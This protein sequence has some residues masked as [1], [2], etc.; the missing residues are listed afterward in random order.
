MKDQ[1]EEENEKKNGKR[2]KKMWRKRWRKRGRKRERSKNKDDTRYH[3]DF[4]LAGF[5]VLWLGNLSP[6]SP[7]V[8]CVPIVVNP[9][10]CHCR[11]TVV[12]VSCHCRVGIAPA[13]CQF[14]SRCDAESRDVWEM[15]GDLGVRN[16]V[17]QVDGMEQRSGWNEMNVDGMR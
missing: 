14:P 16:G 10:S 4:F 5:P 2:K 1:A 12:A 17:G 11:V 9:L 7:H 8:H 13:S 15:N 3:D 6:R